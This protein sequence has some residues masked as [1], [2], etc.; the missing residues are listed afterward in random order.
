MLDAVNN[1]LHFGKRVPLPLRR[2]DIIQE[3]MFGSAAVTSAK[4]P[5]MLPNTLAETNFVSRIA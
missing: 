4:L 5:A 1:L 3:A 2:F